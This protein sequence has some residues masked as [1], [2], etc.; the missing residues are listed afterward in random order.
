M[1]PNSLNLITPYVL[2]EQEDWFEDEIKF[3]RRV[4]QPGQQVIDIGAN[5]GAYTLSMANAVGPTGCDWAFEPASSTARFLADGIAANGFS[6]V[7]LEQIALSSICGTARLSLNVNSEMNSLVHNVAPGSASEIVPLSTLDECMSRQ[8]WRDIEFMKIDAE[9]EEANILKGATRFF[10]QLSPLVQYEIKAG[11]ALHLELVHLFSELGYESYRLV[12]G[13]DLLV[14]FDARATADGYLLNLFCCKRDRAEQLAGRGVLIS[15]A[16]LRSTTAAERLKA[17]RTTIRNRGEYD[18]GNTIARMP[19][20][21]RLAGLWKQRVADGESREVYAALCLYA[22]SRDSS[23][24]PMDRFVALEASSNL[25]QGVCA[26][27]PSC[28]RR[29]SLARAARDYGARSVAANALGTLAKAILQHNQL[30]PGE[31]FLAPGE[32][33]D[34]IPPGDVIGDWV[35]AG[36]LEEYERLGSYS[37]FYTGNSALQRLELIQR[38]GFGSPE[39]QR[40]LRLLQRRFH[41][42]SSYLDAS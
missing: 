8:G 6:N 14:P 4:L 2:M 40:R 13:L 34:A 1:V 10:A 38:I 22:L 11:T 27:Q 37:S 26:R 30:D 16:S 25:L 31:P 29:S 36:V 21:A 12:P 20:G 5:Y 3:L 17:A 19:Y 32:R 39:M 24:R 18:W 23:M 7:V 41:L 9:G 28:L 33:F 35:L 15:H 42:T